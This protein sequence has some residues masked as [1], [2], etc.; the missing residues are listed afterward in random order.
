[1]LELVSAFIELLDKHDYSFEFSDDSRVYRRGL[2]Q[3]NAIKERVAKHP[4]TLTP[5][6]NAYR[7]YWYIDQDTDLLNE[8]I[9]AHKAELLITA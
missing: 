6:F 4:N 1:M 8:R 7:A 5:I 2:A 9:A 3:E